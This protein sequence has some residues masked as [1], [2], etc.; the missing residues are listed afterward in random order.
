[1]KK[2][3]IIKAPDGFYI[4]SINKNGLPSA[5]SHKIT[6]DEITFMFEDI[7]RRHKAETGKNVKVFFHKHEPALIAKVDPSLEECGIMTP[8]MKA[9][10]QAKAQQQAMK[11]Q[12]QPQG[13]RLAV[14]KPQ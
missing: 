8:R 14:P 2:V 9:M 3:G 10:L 6:D 4:G 11:A 5:D 7:M 12:R 13:L 1:M